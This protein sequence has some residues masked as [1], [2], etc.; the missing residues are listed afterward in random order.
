MAGYEGFENLSVAREGRVLVVEIARPKV[1]NALSS[2]TL[3]EI[4]RCFETFATDDEVGAAVLTGGPTE[5]RASFAAGADIAQM[6]DMSGF[7]LRA[8]SRLGQR[9]F[10]AIEQ[11]G[12]PVI[13]AINGFAF[14]GGLELAM[15]CHLRFAAESAKM[16]QPE[17][18]LGIIP[19]FAG[20]QRLPRLVGRG[21]ALEILLGGDPIGAARAAEIG[22]ADRVVADEAL[23][24][25]ALGFAAQLAAKAPLAMQ[26]ILDGVNR[27]YDMSFEDA[28]RLESDLFG[29]VGA[30][31]DVKEGL[32]AFL[33]KRSAE[34]KGR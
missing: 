21:P 25:E 3:S 20:T 2:E 28:Q 31:E 34:F 33:E 32:K 12:K 30:T 13:A 9:A 10:C 6:S 7:E 19:G 11:A 23:R 22:L 29:V 26:L 5:K 14:G 4:H 15:S 1:L 16:G 17:I 18:N 27:G 8:Y 24:E